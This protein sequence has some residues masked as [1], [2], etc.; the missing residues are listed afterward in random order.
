MAREID[1]ACRSNIAKIA[2][3]PPEPLLDSSG[4]GRSR[5]WIGIDVD[6][7]GRPLW[8]RPVDRLGESLHKTIIRRRAASAVCDKIRIIS[9]TRTRRRD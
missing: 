9:Y 3:P 1:A 4:N 7:S 5:A 2:F 8:S 6:G